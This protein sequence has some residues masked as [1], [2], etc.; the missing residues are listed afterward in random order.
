MKRERWLD[1]ALAG[2]AGAQLAAAAWLVPAG[3]A[4]TVA[5]RSLGPLCWVHASTG[6]ACPMCGMT[7]SFVAL[8]HGDAAGSFAAHPAGPF[9]ALAM[10]ALVV[11]VGAAAMRRARPITGRPGFLRAFEGLALATLV[12]GAV[13]AWG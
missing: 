7:R 9:L 2:L 5:G 1:L 8:L 10:A 3:G 12:A 6:V 13:S 4:V 11:A